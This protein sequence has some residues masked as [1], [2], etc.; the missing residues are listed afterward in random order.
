MSETAT[1]PLNCAWSIPY[2][3]LGSTPPI[4]PPATYTKGTPGDLPTPRQEVPTDTA[5]YPVP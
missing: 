1:P 3:Q 2:S 5:P 4:T